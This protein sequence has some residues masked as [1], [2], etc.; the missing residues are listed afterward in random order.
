MQKTGVR[1]VSGMG[2]SF[3]ERRNTIRVLGW[4]TDVI[5][6]DPR[7]HD[8]SYSEFP[9][10]GNHHHSNSSLSLVHTILFWVPGNPGQHDWYKS[11]FIDILS[12]LER[13]FA[14]R[15]VSHAGHGLFGKNNEN[16]SDT[17]KNPITDI[18]DYCRPRASRDSTGNASPRIPWTVE[19][20]VLHKVAY[21]D[22]LLASI[23]KE[24][25]AH[26]NRKCKRER[27]YEFAPDLKFIMI[28]HSFGCHIIQRMCVLRPDILE[29]VSSFL[30][31]MPY[32]RTKPSFAL[33]QRKLDF[34]GSQSELLIAISTKIF[35]TFKSFPKSLIRSAIRRGLDDGN[36]EDDNITNV[37]SKLVTNP[38]YPRNF[39]ELGTEEIRDIPNEIDITALRFLSSNRAS[40]Q[41]D[42]KNSDCQQRRRTSQD[43]RRPISIL[44]A[45]DNDQWSPSFHGEELIC[46]QSA[47]LLPRSVKTTNILG[48]RHDYV[49]QGRSVRSK[50]NDWIISN[51]LEMNLGTISSR[52]NADGY[53][54]DGGDRHSQKITMLRS[55]L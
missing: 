49:C 39:F 2:S 32:I 5:S 45:G 6:V 42:T 23:Q 47:N 3:T 21:I 43:R 53:N 13:G 17:C 33:D 34:G 52:M 8:I 29:R 36:G 50:V 20:Q 35:Q 27:S 48:L 16:E 40:L 19:G 18:K 37:T 11:D 10:S 31:L 24:H 1:R 15:S 7:P 38:V 55:K 12:G 22:S 26:R 14:F 44:Y 9:L 51:I 46:F 25:L 54:A 41:H 28:G 30:F 4:P